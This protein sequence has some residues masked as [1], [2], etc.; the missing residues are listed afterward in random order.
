MNRKNLIIIFTVTFQLMIVLMLNQIMFASDTR[1]FYK[2][3]PFITLSLALMIVM[4]CFALRYVEYY[5]RKEAE[6]EAANSHLKDVEELLNTLKSERHQHSKHIQTIQAML[7]TEEYEELK[8]Y[9]NGIAG[10]YRSTGE[11]LRLGDTV[12]TAVLN[13]KMEAAERNN[14]S[15]KINTGGVRV[16]DAKLSSWELSTVIGNILDNAIEAVMQKDGDRQITFDLQRDDKYYVFTISNN[17]PAIKDA[18]FARIFDPGFS[19]KNR[20]IRGYGLYVVKKIVDG[21]GGRIEIASDDKL[22]SFILRIPKKG[23]LYAS[24]L[25]ADAVPDNCKR[26]KI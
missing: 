26:V 10:G 13:V 6:L 8:K 25:F 2:N 12:L 24:K 15:F 19:T 21:C 20:G 11:L 18:D 17:G 4:L 7:Y 16:K 1:L 23:G 22:T 5:S 9:V 3:L 14:I